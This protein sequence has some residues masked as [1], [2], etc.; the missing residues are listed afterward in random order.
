M[1][2][3]KFHCPNCQGC[4]S[5]GPEWFGKSTGCPH[6]KRLIE[7][8]LPPTST[9]VAEQTAAKPPRRRS[10]P[11]ANFVR[12]RKHFVITVTAVIAAFLG[13]QF[14]LHSKPEP[15]LDRIAK[16]LI[17]D[18]PFVLGNGYRVQNLE[19]EKQG[20][21]GRT[22]TLRS[23]EDYQAFKRGERDRG[24]DTALKGTDDPPHS[25]VC[26]FCKGSGRNQASTLS[27]CP[28]CSGEGTYITRSG[29]RIVCNECG[30]TGNAKQDPTCIYCKGTGRIGW[31]AR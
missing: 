4:I 6:C 24:A 5:A 7:I 16:P 28:R 11:V 26:S 15:K 25:Q 19:I 1:N 10:S 27:R 12:K 3:I 29:H 2:L 30:G 21:D 18:D 8:P 23:S 22:Y 17:T 31:P 13:L 20:S 9:P 14:Y